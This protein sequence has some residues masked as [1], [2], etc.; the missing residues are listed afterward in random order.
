MDEMSPTDPQERPS[1]EHLPVAGEIQA[2]VLANADE[3]N[4]DI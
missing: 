1:K 4:Y 2:D 3:N